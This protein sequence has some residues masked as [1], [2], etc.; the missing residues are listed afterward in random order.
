MVDIVIKNIE[1]LRELPQYYMMNDVQK[2]DLQLT[3]LRMPIHSIYKLELH[4]KLFL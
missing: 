3:E 4:L 2:S 1:R